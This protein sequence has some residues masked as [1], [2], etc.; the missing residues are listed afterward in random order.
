MAEAPGPSFAYLEGSRNRENDL[1]GEVVD[2]VG[3]R[4]NLIDEEF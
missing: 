2:Q 1:Q 4:K 3:D